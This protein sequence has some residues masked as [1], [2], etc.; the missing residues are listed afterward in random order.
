M[1]FPLTIGYLKAILRQPFCHILDYLSETEMLE[2][3]MMY[4]LLEEGLMSP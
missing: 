1:F 4:V 3:V 2:G